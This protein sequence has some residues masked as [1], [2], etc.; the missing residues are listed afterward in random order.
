MSR[1][2]TL[3]FEGFDHGGAL[4]AITI[5][6]GPPGTCVMFHNAIWHTGGR[7][8][9]LAKAALLTGENRE[10]QLNGLLKKADEQSEA[11]I[12]S[13]RAFQEGLA[14]RAAEASSRPGPLSA[15]PPQRG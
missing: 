5:V 2:V 4:M 12:E 9:T 13:L 10:E 7:P 14:L 3:L 15:S 1:P 6:C 8:W 11:S